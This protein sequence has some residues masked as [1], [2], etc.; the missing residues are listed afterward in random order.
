MMRGRE[1]SHSRSKER[2]GGALSLFFRRGKEEAT[3]SQLRVEGWILWSSSSEQLKHLLLLCDCSIPS[4]ASDLASSSS[5]FHSPC[6]WLFVVR[7]EILQHLFSSH[8][9]FFPVSYPSLFVV[10]SSFPPFLLPYKDIGRDDHH[11]HE[12][13]EDSNQQTIPRYVLFDNFHHRPTST[14]D[15][16]GK[17]LST[18][19]RR[20]RERSRSFRRL[21][22]GS[23]C[24]VNIFPF[25]P[26][27]GRIVLWF[28]S[29]FLF[30]SLLYLLLYPHELLSLESEKKAAGI[31]KYMAR[32]ERRTRWKRKSEKR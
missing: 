4:F 7:Q 19:T 25:A 3:S 5:L 17:V 31:E 26:N 8:L 32:A 27:D 20:E 9:F 14:K 23:L 11:H 22:L 2:R 6:V 29:Y 10:P 13:Q 24:L 28:S 12:D 18:S 1:R 30:S 15:E 21:S 16:N